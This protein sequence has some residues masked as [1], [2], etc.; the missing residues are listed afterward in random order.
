MRHTDVW[1]GQRESDPRLVLG[2]HGYCHYT[3][4]AFRGTRIKASNHARPTPLLGELAFGVPL[5]HFETV[6]AR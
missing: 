4:A 1:S 6:G 2:K 3:M 5:E